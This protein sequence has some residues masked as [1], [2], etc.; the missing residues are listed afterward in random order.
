MKKQVLIHVFA[1]LILSF[2]LF[3]FANFSLLTSVFI[4]I[5][6]A[7]LGILYSIKNLKR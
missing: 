4:G 6:A 7:I 3:Y 2:L 1:A 5:G